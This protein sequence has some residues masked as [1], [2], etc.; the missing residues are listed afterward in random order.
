MRRKINKAVIFLLV[1]SVLILPG[2]A[3][4][5]ETRYQASFL[6]L[7]DTVTVIV[8]YAGTEED[9]GALAQEIHD[10]L[11]QFHELYNIYDSYELI[12]NIKTIND[13]AGVKPIPVDSRIVSMLQ[14]GKQVFVMTGGAVNIAMGSV[15]SIW[16]DYREAAINDPENAELPPEDMLKNASAHCNIDDVVIDEEAST[17]YLKD[18]LMRLDVGAVAKGYAVEQVAE[19]LESRG[20][21]SLLLSVGGN[22]R[23]IGSKISGSGKPA[24]WNVGIKNP[25]P[26]AE[27]TELMSAYVKDCSV[28]SS[29]IYERY[30]T[31]GGVQ[32]HHIIDPVTLMPAQHYSQVTIICRDSGLG[33]ALST[34]VFNMPLSRSKAFVEKLDDVEA[35]WILKDG[36][37]VYSDGFKE[38]LD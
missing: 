30:Y 12:N 10:L 4:P 19:Y 11:E 36:T 13:N 15:L 28:I 32:Y 9:F 29:G 35:L 38:Y 23:A 16:H 37:M 1:L 25:E 14:F 21:T 20:L 7:F 33:D 2:C 22:I 5:K 34:A 8:G 3:K 17:V 27:K 24:K 6:D 18:P 31:V 26:G